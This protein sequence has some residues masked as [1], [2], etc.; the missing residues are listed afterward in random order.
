MCR[1][2]TCQSADQTGAPQPDAVTAPPVD[3]TSDDAALDG[4]P[5]SSEP[6]ADL[7]CGGPCEPND[8]QAGAIDVTGGGTFTANLLHAHDDLANNG[9]NLDGGAE[10]FY[11]VE[12]S[13][14][15]VYYFDTFDTVDPLFDTSLRVFPGV[16]CLEVTAAL[17]PVCDDDE[18]ASDQSQLAV[19]LPVGRSC[20]AVDKNFNG[21]HNAD[22][23]VFQ[24]HVVPGKRTGT[25][26]P[27]GV[28]TLF[29]NT[30]TGANTSEPPAGNVALCGGPQ[31][32][33]DLA[34]FFTACPGTPSTVDASTCDNVA[35]THFD[36]ELYAESVDGTS[37]GCID[38][39]PTCAVRPDR[40][41]GKPDGSRL[42]VTTTA[43]GLHWLVIDGFNTACGVYQLNTT[44]R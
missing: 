12:L 15:E 7:S 25:A 24:L 8:Q 26:L 3:S 27:L 37:L 6:D 28:N 2:G 10:V 1:A 17:E 43:V 13:A 20:V 33:K 35:R 18:C 34:Y 36:T 22:V 32:A 14:P 4:G 42:S 19:P 5:V 16:P 40:M 39:T 31:G 38:D 23:G 41:D 29:G 44:Y 9:C 11:Q 21:G 30:C